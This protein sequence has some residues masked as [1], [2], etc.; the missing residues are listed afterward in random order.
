M[1]DEWKQGSGDG[2]A[3]GRSENVVPRIHV[4]LC[5]DRL[6]R[7]QN[8]GAVSVPAARS[9]RALGGGEREAHVYE[10]QEVPLTRSGGVVD[11]EFRVGRGGRGG[12]LASQV[13]VRHGLRL[14]GAPSGAAEVEAGGVVWPLRVVGDGGGRGG[15]GDGGGGDGDRGH[16]VHPRRRLVAVVREHRVQL[17]LLRRRQV[18]F[19]LAALPLGTFPV[20]AVRQRHAEERRGDDGDQRDVWGREVRLDAADDAAG[21]RGVRA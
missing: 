15:G 3:V 14:H 16:A 9:K 5:V 11:D 6:I 1:Y 19:L 4:L 17:G 13:A 10:R 21:R 18:A 2:G 7:Q 12:P 8:N 20:R